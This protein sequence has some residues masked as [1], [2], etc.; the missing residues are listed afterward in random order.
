[1]IFADV[2]ALVYAFRPDTTFHQLARDSLIAIRARG[3]LGVL[4]DVAAAFIRIVTDARLN[5]EPDDAGSALGF[6]DAL[7]ANNRFMREPRSSRWQIFREMIEPGDIRGPLVPDALLAA[8]C[9]D[10]DA[11]ILTA[12]RDFLRFP[13]LR[14]HLMTSMGVISHS[15]T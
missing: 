9:Q 6:I 13:G 2:N 4:S 15:V 3:D 1:L 5:V 7:T 8:T 14:V 12:D 11:G 10:C